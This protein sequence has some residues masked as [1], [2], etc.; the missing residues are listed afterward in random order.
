MS[1]E[2]QRNTGHRDHQKETTGK[3]QTWKKRKGKNV[4]MYEKILQQFPTNGNVLKRKMINGIVSDIKTKLTETK[5]ISKYC[6][7]AKHTDS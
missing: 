6:A 1:G 5:P 7:R 3:S 4:T 2:T